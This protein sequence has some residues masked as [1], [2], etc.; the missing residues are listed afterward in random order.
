ME[1]LQAFWGGLLSESFRGLDGCFR[2]HR[3]G[4]L[5]GAERL[6]EILQLFGVC[7][8]TVLSWG[9]WMFQGPPCGAEGFFQ[10]LLAP[11]GGAQKMMDVL[12]A[13]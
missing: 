2:A 13:F 5:G 8:F 12:Q 10:I 11:L 4:P 3:A 9:W 1:I 6:M 7:F